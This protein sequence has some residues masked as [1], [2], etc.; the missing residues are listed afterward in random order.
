MSVACAAESKDLADGLTAARSRGSQHRD[1]HAIA[2]Y[3]EF[4]NCRE[5]PFK[6]G[7]F[8]RSSRMLTV[9]IA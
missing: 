3:E 2:G 7:Q 9:S 8:W 4:S 5:P 1:R 6:G